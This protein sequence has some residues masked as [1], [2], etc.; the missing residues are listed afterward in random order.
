MNQ[1]Q[2]E[3][4]K[5]AGASIELVGLFLILYN[6]LFIFIL[7]SPFL[8]PL[9]I[10]AV[11]GLVFLALGWQVRKNPSAFS[12]G[13]LITSLALSIILLVGGYITTK[14]TGGLSMYLLLI[15]LVSSLLGLEAI[16]KINSPS[17]S[18]VKLKG[19][20][21]AKDLLKMV[22]IA[23]VVIGLFIGVSYFALN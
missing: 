18:E 3:K 12:K 7:K 13:K 9:V 17:N 21:K 6:L 2:V 16:R 10:T 22:L 8:I 4:I 5:K 23:I 1:N 11:I 20:S 14:T 19:S 15:I